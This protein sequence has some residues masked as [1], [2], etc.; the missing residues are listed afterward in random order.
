MLATNYSTA[1]T[2][3]VLIKNTLQNFNKERLQWNHAS[4]FG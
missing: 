2:S 1:L 4:M 3:Q